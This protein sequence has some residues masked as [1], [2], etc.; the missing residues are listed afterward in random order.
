MFFEVFSV[1]MAIGL[2]FVLILLLVRIVLEV[3]D[4]FDALVA[5]AERY[6]YRNVVIHEYYDAEE[7]KYVKAYENPKP[8]AVR[9][10]KKGK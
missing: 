1:V 9:L 8:V 7:M 5:A 3:T 10:A 2:A 6:A 4:R